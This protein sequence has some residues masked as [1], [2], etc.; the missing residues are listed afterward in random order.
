MVL[1]A[2]CL[3]I[4]LVSWLPVLSTNLALVMMSLWASLL[5]IAVLTR[6]RGLLL[7]LAGLITGMIWHWCWGTLRLHQTLPAVLEGVDLQLQGTVVGLPLTTEFGQSFD[8]LVDPDQP[9]LS[10]RTLRLNNFGE[11]FVVAGER[12]QLELRLKR[13]HG[14]ANPGG[15]DREA[16][17]LRQGYAATGY[18]RQ[19]SGNRKLGNAEFRFPNLVS[20]LRS[21]LLGHLQERLRTMQHSELMLALVLGER[22]QLKREHWRLF[23]ATGTNHLFVISGLHIGLVSLFCFRLAT[24]LLKLI[25]PMLLCC[26]AQWGAALIS[27]MVALAYSLLAGWGLPTQR[28]CIMVLLFLSAFLS[29]R[30][31]GL[32]LRFMLALVLVL[33]L[34]PL[35]TT[36]M[37]FWLSFSAVGVLLFFVLPGHF[38]VPVEPVTAPRSHV[39]YSYLSPQW[40]VFLGLFVP[41]GMMLG[42]VSLLAPLANLLTI[43]IL[44]ML[45]LPL[46]LLASLFSMVQQE[47]S[48]GLFVSADVVLHYILFLLESLSRLAGAPGT[49]SVHSVPAASLLFIVPGIILLLTARAQ[50]YRHLALPLLLPLFFSGEA[51]VADGL[52]VH[53]LD[54][55]QGLAVLLQTQNH[56]LLYDTGPGN[57]ADWNA[58]E[59]IVIPALR[60]LGVGRLDRI[61]VSHGDSDHAGGLQSILASFPDNSTWSHCHF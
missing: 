31:C 14:F 4:Y 2:Y 59:A 3:G 43:P 44:A 32:G 29:R 15:N 52:T 5:G 28:A 48:H 16:Y 34:D 55:G 41:L 37:G 47:L 49:L 23:T 25:P 36:S 17:L 20:Q 57:G 18:L 27:M 39:W 13:P 56:S 58:G 21:R 42:Q 19:G 33:S 35:A 11:E 53:V 10:Q 38:Q 45:L 40:Y 60:K 8:F 7:F 61:I 24:W 46:L 1:A 50:P 30:R 26:P 6:R 12:W 54:V 51:P 22:G 9:E